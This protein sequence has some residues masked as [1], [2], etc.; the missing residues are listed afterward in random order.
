MNNQ[1][2]QQQQHL[3]DPYAQQSL[4][5]GYGSGVSSYGSNAYST[6]DPSVL[7]FSSLSRD[8]LLVSL[9]LSSSYAT[10][11]NYNYN[12]QANSG[13]YSYNG[14]GASNSGSS[15][16]SQYPQH[17]MNSQYSYAP[18]NTMGVNDYY[19]Q[20]A[21]YGAAQASSGVYT[22]P[23]GMLLRLRSSTHISVF[24]A[25]GVGYDYN[26]YMAPMGSAGINGSVAHNGAGGQAGNS[27]PS[28]KNNYE[29]ENHYGISKA[30][31]VTSPNYQKYPIS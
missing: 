25:Y 29:H 6:A 3:Y 26:S 21:G 22:D 13:G 7:I 17:Q 15:S 8:S 12:Q 14:S 9:S 20:Y 18:T 28:E 30:S 2:Q 16:Y 23:N 27:S 4:Y 10:W 31:L 5:S 24:L 11:N 1:G 19:S